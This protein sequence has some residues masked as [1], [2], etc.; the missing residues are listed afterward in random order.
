[1][2]KS[3]R[4]LLILLLL[5]AAAVGYYFL[6]QRREREPAPAPVTGQLVVHFLDVGQGDSELIRLPS[7]GTILID[8]GARGAPTVE[9]LKR[10]GVGDIDLVIAT[11][12]HEDH[13]GEM[14][15]V[16]R[17]FKVKE[18]WDPGFAYPTRTY[19]NMLKEI[20]SQNI[21]FENPK[22][23]HTRAFGDV[24]LEVLH[25][26]ATFI[27]EDRDDAN[28]ASMV[29]RLTF[30][31]KR[32]LFTGD[33]EEASWRQMIDANKSSLR[34]DLLKAAHHGSDDG[35]TGNVLDA[36]RPEI[37]TISCA[38]GNDYHHPHHR[39]V[40]LLEE[41]RSQIKPYRTDLQGTITATSDGN[42]IQMSTERTVTQDRLYLTGDEA[43]GKVASDDSGR[44]GATRKRAA[45]GSR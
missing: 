25:P 14:V 31:N 20:D 43:A 2:R 23:G 6:R 15:D 41:R 40:R 8:T 21:K 17:A 34:A 45:K 33:A 7:G 36:V 13:I 37:V 16:M 11:H 12:P 1:M 42:S 5:A 26:G 29:V 3:S 39:V 27:S 32:F 28:D 35:T 4:S 38:I 10:L 24:T 19:L 9:M 44:G 18:V 22:R 30:G